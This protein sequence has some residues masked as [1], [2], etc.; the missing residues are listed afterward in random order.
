VSIKNTCNRCKNKGTGIFCDFIKPLSKLWIK[1][2]NEVNKELEKYKSEFE[3]M[4]NRMTAMENKYDM[5]LRD[6]NDI[7]QKLCS[8][9]QK[10]SDELKNSTRELLDQNKK[11]VTE[12]LANTRKLLS[13]VGKSQGYAESEQTDT[14]YKKYVDSI[15]EKSS[16]IKK[17]N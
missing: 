3:I 9:L 13:E 7:I 1:D 8:Q 5:S 12:S 16:P 14:E 2:I 11:R 10:C 15:K 6:K 4:R 17:N